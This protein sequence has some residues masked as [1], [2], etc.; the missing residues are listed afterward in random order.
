MARHSACVCMLCGHTKLSGCF[1][2]WS[3]LVEYLVQQSPSDICIVRVCLQHVLEFLMPSAS[4]QL[5]S[6]PMS[7]ELSGQCLSVDKVVFSG[8]T[9][10]SLLQC[11]LGQSDDFDALL[12]G[13]SLH[14]AKSISSCRHD[15]VHEEQAVSPRTQQLRPCISRHI[16]QVLNQAACLCTLHGAVSAGWS[17][18]TPWSRK[19]VASVH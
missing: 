13:A 16:L 2:Q 1:R 11:C 18:S 14:V 10:T 9:Y 3:A 19:T 7:S 4:L 8:A 6:A 15:D 17:P 5:H 12:L